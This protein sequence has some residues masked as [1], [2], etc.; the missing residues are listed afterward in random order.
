MTMFQNLRRMMRESQT[1]KI[2]CLACDHG[3]EW[4]QAEA[5]AWL[6]PDVTPFEIR[7]KLVCRLCG[8]RARVWI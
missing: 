3:A 4:T 2:H 1:L 8:G 5:F 7:E 6:G